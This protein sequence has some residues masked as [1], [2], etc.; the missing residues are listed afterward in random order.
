MDTP[1]NETA[2]ESAPKME[3][4]E[5]EIS[6]E[7]DLNLAPEPELEQAKPLKKKLVG[8]GLIVAG[9]VLFARS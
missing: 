5:R 6:D 1:E 2:S 9:V 8:L 7:E 4:R 3:L